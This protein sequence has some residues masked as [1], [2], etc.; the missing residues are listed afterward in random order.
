MTV[1]QDEL[2]QIKGI[3]A[4][5]AAASTDIQA[6]FDALKGNPA[7]PVAQQAVQDALTALGKQAAALDPGPQPAPA[8]APDP[9][10]APAPTPD[11]APAPDPQP[12]QPVVNPNEQPFTGQ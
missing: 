12:Q 1:E 8:P 10:P 9:A 7:D 4:S 3:G 6:K 11:P 2:A 5:L